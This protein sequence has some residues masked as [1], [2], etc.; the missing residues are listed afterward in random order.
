MNPRPS[1]PRPP[2]KI[3]DVHDFDARKAAREL[4]RVGFTAVDDIGGQLI[5]CAQ[6]ELFDALGFASDDLDV[7]VEEIR[8][9][10][11]PVYVFWDTSRACLGAAR[12]F[13][14]A[15]RPPVER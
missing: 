13:V 15:N 4:L 2:M 14:K 3:H 5:D 11:G 7:Q 1:R 12:A 9:D 8:T 10:W 6:D